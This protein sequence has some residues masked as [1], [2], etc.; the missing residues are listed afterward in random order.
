MSHANQDNNE[1][2]PNLLHCRI[3]HNPNGILDHLRLRRKSVNFPLRPLPPHLDLLDPPG[4]PV[5]RRSNKDV[6]M[7]IVKPKL[8]GIHCKPQKASEIAIFLFFL[9]FHG[10]QFGNQ[11]P[12]GDYLHREDFL[13]NQQVFPGSKPIFLHQARSACP[14]LQDIFLFCHSRA[15]GNPGM[16][17]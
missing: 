5:T 16:A 8:I 7:K 12:D 17:F 11:L 1:V 10:R 4:I 14:S 9:R 3:L 15:S 6:R 13:F 2:Q